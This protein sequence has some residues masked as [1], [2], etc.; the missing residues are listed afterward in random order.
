MRWINVISGAFTGGVLFYSPGRVGA[1]RLCTNFIIIIITVHNG[2]LI[3]R[4][5]SLYDDDDDDG[6]ELM[7]NFKL[8]M[9]CIG[10]AI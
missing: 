7:M 1:L 10:D 8:M 3:A 6:D 4:R 5:T 9:M 2:N